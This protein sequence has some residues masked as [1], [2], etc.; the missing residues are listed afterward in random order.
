MEKQPYLTVV[1]A[2]E[3]AGK[4]VV[5]MENG[6][7]P[8]TTTA[9][10]H[11]V[12]GNNCLPREPQ[13]YSQLSLHSHQ[14]EGDIQ[15]TVRQPLKHKATHFESSVDVP[16][17]YIFVPFQVPSDTQ[18]VVHSPWIHSMEQFFEE[19]LTVQKSLRETLGDKAPYFV[20]KE[21]PSYKGDFSH[22]HNRDSHCIFANANNTQELI[23]NAQAVITI[24]STVGLES[25]LRTE[26]H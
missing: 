17:N 21:H 9:D 19:L 4:R 24:N 7:L 16:T 8:K 18:I 11:G 2:A 26:S 1:K 12:N 14:E 25:L 15:L 13:F 3:A 22:L 5:Y 20:F 23:Q 10:F 6:L